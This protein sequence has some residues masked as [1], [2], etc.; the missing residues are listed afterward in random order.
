MNVLS[1][2]LRIY[3]ILIFRGERSLNPLH[4]LTILHAG[5]GGLDL[6]DFPQSCISPLPCADISKSTALC[7]ASQRKCYFD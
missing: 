3:K 6:V 7:L 1:S 4:L 5:S 2:F